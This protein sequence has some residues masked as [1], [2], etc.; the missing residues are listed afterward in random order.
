M[1]F[2]GPIGLGTWSYIAIGAALPQFRRYRA[3][4]P[5]PEPAIATVAP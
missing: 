3:T 1:K 5:E 2:L 4:T